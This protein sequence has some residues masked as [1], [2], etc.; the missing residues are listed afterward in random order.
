M[1]AG[2]RFEGRE[3]QYSGLYHLAQ[4][5]FGGSMTKGLVKALVKSFLRVAGG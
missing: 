5:T 4:E 2:E 3:Q 1:L